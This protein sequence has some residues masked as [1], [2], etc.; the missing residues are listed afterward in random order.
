MKGKVVSIGLDGYNQKS[1]SFPIRGG[2]HTYI[3]TFDK[4]IWYEELG[5]T[6]V[7]GLD[8]KVDWHY[9]KPIDQA[10]VEL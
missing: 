6:A 3:E 7:I 9:G 4:V 1:V 2:S 10:H 8:L 5:M